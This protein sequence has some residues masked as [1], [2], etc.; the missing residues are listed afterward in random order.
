MG[1]FLLCVKEERRQQL[2]STWHT[3][4]CRRNTANLLGAGP[5]RCEIAA[6]FSP[7]EDEM[8]VVRRVSSEPVLMPCIR[9]QES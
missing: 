5:G 9:L 6:V 8:K 7:T 4:Y 1:P 2:M 3:T